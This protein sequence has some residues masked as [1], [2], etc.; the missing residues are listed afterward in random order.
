VQFS[1]YFHYSYGIKPSKAFFWDFVRTAVLYMGRNSLMNQYRLG[2]DQLES[3]FAKNSL[4]S[5]WTT[6]WP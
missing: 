6:N 4:G 2:N 5:W 3:S 1:D